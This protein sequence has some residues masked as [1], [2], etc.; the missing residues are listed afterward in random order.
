MLSLSW[1]LW[2]FSWRLV[3][4]VCINTTFLLGNKMCCVL[5]D[6]ALSY[7]FTEFNSLCLYRVLCVSTGESHFFP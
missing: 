7:I 6:T 5:Q 3:I 4:S 2:T 1:S